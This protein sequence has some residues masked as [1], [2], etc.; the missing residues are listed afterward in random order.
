MMTYRSKLINGKD[1]IYEEL[2]YDLS[3]TWMLF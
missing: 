2:H 3:F 1:T